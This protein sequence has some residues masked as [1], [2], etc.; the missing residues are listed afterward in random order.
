M[1]DVKVT[2]DKHISRSREPDLFYSR[3]PNN[4]GGGGRGVG[5]LIIAGVGG[6]MEGGGRYTNLHFGL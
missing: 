2:K 3:V 1:M 4:R 6:I 5:N